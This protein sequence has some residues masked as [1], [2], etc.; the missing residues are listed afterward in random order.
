MENI[1][2]NIMKDVEE[3]EETLHGFEKKT[4]SAEDEL[5]LQEATGLMTNLLKVHVR[6]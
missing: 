6:D 3:M 2:D 1:A 5:V 4:I